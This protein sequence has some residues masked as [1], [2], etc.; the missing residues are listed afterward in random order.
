MSLLV[1]GSVAFDRI[2]T[3]FGEQDD[4]LA[5]A[6]TYFSIAAS[7][8]TEV[9]VVGIVGDDF[10]ETHEAIFREREIDLTYL[11]R[12][13]GGKS[14][15]WF[16]EYSYDFN[17]RTTH[18]TQLN[19]FADFKP[20][21]APAAAEMTHL[22][23]GNIH[24]ELQANVRKQSQ[25]KIVGMDTMNFWISG[26]PD[27]LHEALKEIDLLIIND[28]EARQL[29]QEPN[30]IRAA[31]KIRAMGPKRLIV[32]RGEYG[33]AL[34]G[35][36]SYF[37]I[38]GYPQEDVVDPTGA[39]DTFAGGVMGYLAAT[40]N[41]IEDEAALRRAMIYGSVM[42]SFTIE[43]FGTDRLL[44]LTYDEINDRFRTFKAITHFEEHLHEF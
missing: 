35:E 8:F 3:P 41:T 19:V 39:G 37:A 11:E 43:S 10:T 40:N 25:A 16:G 44:K 32:K 27:S 42:A 14:F 21:L 31:R 17:T 29:A 18:D 1:V 15:R 22:F 12:V 36:N 26:T 23:L 2:K 33:A 34:F 24:P 5:G 28:E 9:S 6:A 13:S 20:V 38:P 4:I 30:V 7:F